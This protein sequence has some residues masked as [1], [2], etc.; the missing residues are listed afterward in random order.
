V[1]VIALLSGAA[2]AQTTQPAGA[3]GPQL[4]PDLPTLWVVGDSTANNNANGGL[5]W[6]APFIKLFDS[7]KVNVVNRARGGRSSRSFQ[8][9]G[10]W[11][12]VLAQMKKGDF[13]IIQMGHNDGGGTDVSN[14]NGRP[15]L[16]GLGEETKEIERNGQKEIVHTYGWYMR[17]YIAD[18]RAKG[19]TPIIAS[20]VPHLPRA[21]VAE[22]Q[23]ETNFR[24]VGWAEEVAKAENAIFIHVNKGVLGHY[25]GIDPA[26]L[27][28]NYFTPPGDGTHTNPAG[29][30]LNAQSV[31]EALKELKDLPI[32]DWVLAK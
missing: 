10:L 21:V 16:G 28:T 20:S 22:G 18:T 11:D 26:E 7:S 3:S 4:N 23:V 9:E 17:K 32:K 13:V 25:K 5:G 24:Q 14:P 6:G 27:R 29:A 30:E 19:A 1:F 2:T 15:S 12:A 31:V 8:A